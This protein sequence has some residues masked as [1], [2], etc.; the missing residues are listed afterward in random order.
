MDSLLNLCPSG[1]EG[2]QINVSLAL[3]GSNV[4]M[5]TFDPSKAKL[6]FICSPSN[7]L[8]HKFSKESIYRVC[9]YFSDSGLVVLE[10]QDQN[11]KNI[12]THDKWILC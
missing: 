4:S 11:L 6:T 3:L 12:R 2:E 1:F 9:E 7:P 10:P 5:E 8:G